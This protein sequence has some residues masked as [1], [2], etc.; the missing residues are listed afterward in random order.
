M[1]KRSIKPLRTL[2]LPFSLLAFLAL[3]V[4]VSGCKKVDIKL[5]NQIKTF[6]PRW[7]SLGEE[8]GWVDQN[9]DLME[10][11]FESDFQYLEPLFDQVPDSLNGPHF[12]NLKKQY[13]KLI[14]SRDEIRETYTSTKS[15]YVELV[16]SF[17]E[18]ETKVMNGDVETSKAYEELREYKQKHREMLK[19]AE[20]SRAEMQKLASEHNTI[21][22]ELAVMTNTPTNLDLKLKK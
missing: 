2:I 16:E 10:G 9:L 22:R 8:L 4:G 17:N 18:W 11:R 19:F 13:P 12:R 3:L 15:A 6:E 14:E 1:H 7:A 21:L 20:D 5:V